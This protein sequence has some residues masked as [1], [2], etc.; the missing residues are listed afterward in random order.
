MKLYILLFLLL[1]FATLQQ[2]C[3]S[4]LTWT[5]GEY[6]VSETTAPA[7][8]SSAPFNLTFTGTGTNSNWGN[9]PG[10]TILFEQFV[11]IRDSYYRRKVLQMDMLS[12]F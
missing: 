1:S 3:L 9:A 2:N 5:K 4:G 7:W 12:R 11:P 6:A 8:T 10:E